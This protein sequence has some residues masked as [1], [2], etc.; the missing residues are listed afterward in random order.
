MSSSKSRWSRSEFVFVST[1][2][3]KVLVVVRAAL[4][5]GSKRTMN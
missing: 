3:D 2:P 1:K 5:A 4:G